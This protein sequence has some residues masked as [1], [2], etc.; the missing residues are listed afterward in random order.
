[1]ID[2]SID[3]HNR[4]LDLF[5]GP[6]E[7]QGSLAEALGWL[8][9]MR[10]AVINTTGGQDDA[11]VTCQSS[12]AANG[13]WRRDTT[14]VWVRDVTLDIAVAPDAAA[15]SGVRAVV[16]VPWTCDARTQ[17]AAG[18]LSGEAYLGAHD[19]LFAGRPIVPLAHNARKPGV[20]IEH[21]PG[22]AQRVLVPQIGPTVRFGWS[23][24]RPAI[25]IGNESLVAIDRL[26]V[27]HRERVDRVIFGR[28]ASPL[29]MAPALRTQWNE[30][31]E[32]LTTLNG[33]SAARFEHM[34]ARVEAAEARVAETAPDRRE[35]RL[36][37]DLL[38]RQIVAATRGA[39]L[40]WAASGRPVGF[41]G[42]YV[43]HRVEHAARRTTASASSDG[44][45]KRAGWSPNSGHRE[46]PTFA[47]G[48]HGCAAC[49]PTFEAAS[50]LSSDRK[51]NGSASFEA[52]LSTQ[53]CALTAPS[54]RRPNQAPEGS[55]S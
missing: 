55:A 40:R 39:V 12:V 54:M 2:I 38:R 11:T 21:R 26:P 16:G 52:L 23:G 28:E 46:R 1:M 43:A 35:F 34:I 31:L 20:W 17:N 4:S 9:P 15:P 51:A 22:G 8:F 14:S 36:Y 24:R 49:T 3:H 41:L 13:H 25:A 30:L 53:H 7:L 42:S 29:I 47:A 37:G 5:G 50:A 19:G 48:A 44:A 32:G 33:I 6:P 27:G 10:V 18:D 45:S